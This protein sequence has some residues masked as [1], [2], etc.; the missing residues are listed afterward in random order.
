[1]ADKINPSYYKEGSI[2]VCDFIIDKNLNYCQG[3]VVKYLIRYPFKNGI[4]D[5]QKA[6]W[7]LDKLIQE[8]EYKATT[9]N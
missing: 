5:L 9:T 3:N 7:Y 4:E 1:M 6:K 2:E 8:E